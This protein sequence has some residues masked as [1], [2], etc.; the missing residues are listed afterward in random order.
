MNPAKKLHDP[1]APSADIA[2]AWTAE[3]AERFREVRDGTV[4]LIELDEVKQRMRARRAARRPDVA[5]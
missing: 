1:H 5:E 4:P 3:L 2:E